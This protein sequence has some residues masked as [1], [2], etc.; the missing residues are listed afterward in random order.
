MDDIDTQGDEQTRSNERIIKLNSE[1]KE[2]EA[3]A[4]EAETARATAE[5]ATAAATKERDFYASFTQSTAKYPGASEYTDKIKEKVLAGYTV[6]DATVS[7][8]NSEGKLAVTAP[9]VEVAPAAGGSAV[10][11]LPDGGQKTLNEM[12]RDE[13]RAALMD[14]EKKGNISLT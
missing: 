5:A 8:L 1:K 6:E 11:H 14:E 4:A 9:T 7:V 3:K 13:K 12:T 2:A 10:N